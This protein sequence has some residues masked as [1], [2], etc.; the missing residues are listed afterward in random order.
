MLIYYI[1]FIA[2]FIILI[3]LMIS[4][5]RDPV[6]ILE[7][8]ALPLIPF[9]FTFSIF[10]ALRMYG[11]A[12]ILINILG[13]ILTI[14]AIRILKQKARGWEALGKVIKFAPI[15]GAALGCFLG[16]LTLLIP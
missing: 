12:V 3:W 11:V 10:Y 4:K 6:F 2:V 15:A 5:N 1:I 8:T 13:L 9:L 14:Y 16:N 7:L